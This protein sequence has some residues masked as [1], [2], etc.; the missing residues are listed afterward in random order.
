MKNFFALMLALLMITALAGC[1]R[2]D[3]EPE[4]EPSQVTTPSTEP[5]TVPTLPD[6][7]MPSSNIPD[8][9]VDSNSGNNETEATTK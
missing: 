7:T 1:G 2:K 9:T 3:T 4:T 5:I 8:P 6:M